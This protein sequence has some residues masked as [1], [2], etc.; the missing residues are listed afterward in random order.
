MAEIK[1]R[2]HAMQK[3]CTNF[4]MIIPKHL[5]AASLEEISL[6]VENLCVLYK[7]D[8]DLSDLNRELNSLKSW[9]P[10]ILDTDLDD[11][12]PLEY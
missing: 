3:I 12:N 2:Y 1:K 10:T 5:I 6:S 4:K 11:A 8:F 9:L 7:D